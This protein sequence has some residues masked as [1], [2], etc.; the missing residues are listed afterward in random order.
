MSTPPGNGRNGGN[1]GNGRNGRARVFARWHRRIGLAAAILVLL[2]AVTGILLSHGE[3]FGLHRVHVTTP[4]IVRLYDARPS[5]PPRASRAGAHWVLWIDGRIF[6]DGVA[7]EGRLDG[8]VGAVEGPGVIAVAGPEALLLLMPAGALVE[9]IGP[10]GLPGR[11]A[12]IGRGADGAIVL[13][14]SHGSFATRDGLDFVPLPESSD[15]RWDDPVTPVPAAAL[16]PALA[17]FRGDGVP[18]HRIVADLHSGRVL[19]AVGPYL[20]DAAAIAL[21]LLAGSGLVLWRRR[22]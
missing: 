8:L 20:M 19:G 17:A 2:L 6:L 7:T 9:R 5:V 21:I 14:T 3:A 15:I 22:R 11:I 16:A 4:W 18:L 12:R 1:G 10:E 13:A